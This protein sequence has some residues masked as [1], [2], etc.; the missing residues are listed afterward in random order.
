MRRWPRVPAPLSLKAAPLLGQ[1][2]LLPPDAIYR[3]QQVCVQGT[4]WRAVCPPA[5]SK[6]VTVPAVDA[7]SPSPRRPRDGSSQTRLSHTVYSEW[8][9]GFSGGKSVFCEPSRDMLGTSRN[10]LV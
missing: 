5:V 2:L 6:P 10:A 3:H 4:S 1:S 9:S 7:A 8:M